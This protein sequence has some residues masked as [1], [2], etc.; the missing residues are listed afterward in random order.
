MIVNDELGKIWKQSIMAYFKTLCQNLSEGTVRIASFRAQIISSTATRCSI[1]QC[2]NIS[3]KQVD[4]ANLDDKGS[5][6]RARM[7]LGAGCEWMLQSFHTVKRS[8]FKNVRS[9]TII[10][11][12]QCQ[13]YQ[14][15]INH[16]RSKCMCVIPSRDETR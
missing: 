3:R 2:Q 12:T 4:A 15:M 9:Q 16:G 6:R 5:T 8:D 13:I 14:F 1:Q 11:R 7:L 10:S